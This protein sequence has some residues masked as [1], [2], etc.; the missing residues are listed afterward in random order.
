M[1]HADESLITNMNNQEA[2]QVWEGQLRLAVKD[3]TLR[4]LFKNKGSQFHGRGFKML[5]PLMQH[6]RPN[7]VTNAFSSLL[8]LFNNV[9]GELESIIEY[10]SWFNGLTIKLARCK[11]VIPL[12]LLVM[13]FLCALHGCYSLILEQF[14]THFKPIEEATLDSIVSDVI[15]NDG[16]HMVEHSKKVK[17]GSTPPG[18]CM[19]A[20]AAAN[21]N[22]NQNGKVWQTPFEWLAKY[23]EKGIKSRWTWALAGTGICP[24]CHQDKLPHHIPAQCPLLTELN[25][26]LVSG[27]LAAATPAPGPAPSPAPAP[28]P[29]G[30]AAA[31]DASS[32]LGCSVSSAPP[33]GLTAALAPSP[34]PSGDYESDE[35]YHLDGDDLGDEYVAHPKVNKHIVLYSLLCSHVSVVSP[36]STSALS[37][38][39]GPWPPHLSL[40]L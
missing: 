10:W 11:V 36:S 2:S 38:H 39:L 5:A 27:P 18:S 30:H 22:S 17:P 28:S 21:T 37:S 15:Y 20:T 1:G 8:S 23:G 24:I 6:C 3:S 7:T 31:A 26:K 12:L 16:F 4:F 40:V 34:S 32:T 14:H 25:L 33:S 35:D 9:Q 29:G 19:P 13:L